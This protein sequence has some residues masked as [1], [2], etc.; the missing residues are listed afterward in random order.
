MRLAPAITWDASGPVAHTRLML[1]DGVRGTGQNGIN[2]N[3][4]WQIMLVELHM[5]RNPLYSW[6]AVVLGFLRRLQC[7][8]YCFAFLPFI[9]A[10]AHVFSSVGRGVVVVLRMYA[11]HRPSCP[12][13]LLCLVERSRWPTRKPKVDRHGSNRCPTC[14]RSK[15][16]ATKNLMAV[17]VAHPL[18]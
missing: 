10:H 17:S 6:L 2:K 1:M 5:R 18:T 11:A 15:F 4:R 12:P 8:V 9:S 3:A 7:A 14:I 13:T 16:G